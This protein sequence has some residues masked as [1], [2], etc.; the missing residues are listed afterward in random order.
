MSN[1][2]K[3]STAT[4]DTGQFIELIR[5]EGNDEA[6]QLLSE[7]ENAAARLRQEAE[8]EARTI[9]DSAHSEGEERGRRAQA[10]L[11]A[12]TDASIHRDKL[13][14]R[15][16]LFLDTLEGA[17][18][19]LLDF[20]SF[21]GAAHFLEDLI[22]EALAPLPGGPVVIQMPAAYLQ[23]ADVPR[24]QALGAGKWEIQVVTGDPPEGGGIIAKTTDGRLLFD[25]SFRER[26]RRI[27]DAA[28]TKAYAILLGGRSP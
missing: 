6:Q 26:L 23:L 21:P 28:R 2:D 4:D 27:E 20:P 24:V 11:L 5:Q 18:Q 10:R 8:T 12:E 9:R 7:A 15:E 1:P 17:R 16:K 19:K 14:A 22:R 13:W 25:N 3:T